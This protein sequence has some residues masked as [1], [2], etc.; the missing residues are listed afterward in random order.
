MPAACSERRAACRLPHRDRWRPRVNPASL[1]LGALPK[2]PTGF[3][4]DDFTFAQNVKEIGKRS[5]NFLSETYRLVK[6]FQA[7]QEWRAAEVAFEIHTQ[8]EYTVL[9]LSIGGSNRQILYTPFDT[10]L[11]SRARRWGGMEQ[12]KVACCAGWTLSAS[13]GR[14]VYARRA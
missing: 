6:K 2:L 8:S 4:A 13:S 10:F 5:L 11:Y 12:E 14:P 7:I 1:H 3:A 9:I